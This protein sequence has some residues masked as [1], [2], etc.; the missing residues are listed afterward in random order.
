M[1]DAAQGGGDATGGSGAMTK[2]NREEEER[3]AAGSDGT[4]KQWRLKETKNDVTTVHAGEFNL[5]SVD[6]MSSDTWSRIE[7]NMMM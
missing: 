1:G 4:G 2:S 6:I 5:I 7:R 3:R